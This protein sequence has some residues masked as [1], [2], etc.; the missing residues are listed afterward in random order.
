MERIIDRILKF[1]G[2]SYR[3]NKFILKQDVKTS[4]FNWKPL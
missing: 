4:I 2:T 3:A 1:P